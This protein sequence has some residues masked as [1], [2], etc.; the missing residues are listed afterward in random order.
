MPKNVAVIETKNFNYPYAKTVNV[1][2]NYHGTNVTDP[3]RW[4]EE[5]NSEETQKWVSEENELTSSFIDEVRTNKKI[6]DRISKL[7]N[8]P[9]LSL[10]NKAGN[11]YFFMKNNGLQNQP[12]LNM[13]ETLEGEDKLILDP[14]VFSEDGTIAISSFDLSKDGKLMVYAL[15]ENG[16]DNTELKIKNIDTGLDFEET[17]KWT[18]FASISWKHDN[19]GFFYNRFPDPSTV[20]SEETSSFNKVYY[21]KLGTKQDEDI[22]IYERLDDK[23]LS[24][25]SKITDDGKY[26][27]LLIDRD[28]SL[29]EMFYYRE[30]ESNDDFIRLID[31]E[32]A[33]YELIANDD[34]IFYFQTDLN[35]P[36]GKIISID[37]NNPEKENWKDVIKEQEDIIYNVQF[38]N[39]KFVVVYLHDAYHKLKIFNLNGD[40]EKEIELPTLGSIADIY[41][42]RKDDTLFILFTSYAYPASIFTYDFKTESLNL[43]YKAQVEFNPN[44]FE[45]KQVFVNS[46]DGTKVPMFLTYKKGLKLDGNNPTIVYAYGGF[47]HS[48][49]PFFSVA[50]LYWLEIGG[51][52]ALANI[53]GG[54]EYGDRWHKAGMLEKKQN[55]FDDFISCGEWLIENK[56]T[57]K[58]K[59]VIKG[60]S[61][62]GLLVAACMLQRPDLFASVICS[63]P[64]IDMLRYHKFTVGRFWTGEYGNA[65]KYPEHFKFMYEY[66]PLHNIKEGQTYPPTLILTAD[67]DDR[68]VPSHSF[69]FAASLQKADSGKNPILLRVETKAGH[70]GGKPTLKM[71]EENVDIYAFLIKVLNI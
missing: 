51:I 58:S 10:P 1:I 32:E 36:N 63:V 29:K 25:M 60:G 21:H 38:V 13:R 12:V 22:L 24:F 65:E 59:L 20:S 31:K 9:K 19:S 55:T 34:S 49:P 53:R 2:D 56:Y 17:I 67:T 48:L 15:S 41:G 5:Q 44:D 50:N 7:W 39:N 42:K 6:K 23:E 27:T 62:G 16:S 33:F 18:K 64:V 45:T 57:S 8:Y 69:K 30:L 54:G 66:S 61:N 71:I 68:V 3:Y 37:I 28:S 70:G 43:F 14:N 40:F 35:S 26:L 46:K 11:R 4:L 47:N 52:F